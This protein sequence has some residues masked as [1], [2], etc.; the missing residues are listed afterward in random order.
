MACSANLPAETRGTFFFLSPESAFPSG[1]ANVKDL[2][3]FSLKE[4]QRIQFLG[5]RQGIRFWISPDEVARDLDV[6]FRVLNPRTREIH[7]LMNMEHGI[8]EAYGEATGERVHVDAEELVP[9]TDDLGVALPLAETNLRNDPQWKSMTIT[10]AAAHE[11]LRVLGVR[12]EWLNVSPVKNPALRGWVPVG[13]VVT[14]FDFATH[15]LPK[16]GKWQSVLYRKGAAL[17]TSDGGELA[18]DDV[19]A[20]ITNAEKGVALRAMEQFNL[21]AR[22]YVQLIKPSAKDW[23]ESVL[24]DHGRV[25][26]KRGKEDIAVGE[27]RRDFL[28]SSESMLQRQILSAAFHPKN[29]QVGLISAEGIFLTQ[30]GFVWERLP[31][32]EKSDYPVAINSAGELFVGPFRSQDQGKT[33]QPY[34]KWDSISAFNPPGNRHHPILR[35]MKIEPLDGSRV[36]LSLNNGVRSWKLVGDARFGLLNPWK[37]E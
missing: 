11:R 36:R 20:L 4:H 23:V 31:S 12:G 17:I 6:S 3:R 1:Q 14:K 2:E 32:F 26:W 19:R 5:E 15:A 13:N 10:R 22:G 37:L 27:L 7:W 18:I 9:L 25:F 34:L 8:A 28:L 21:P 29:P 30:D 35:L 24:P 16:K 33:F